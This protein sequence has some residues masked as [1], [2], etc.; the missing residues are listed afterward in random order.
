MI[1]GII[2]GT[3]STVFIAAAIAIIWQGR[4]PLKGQAAGCCGRRSASGRAAPA[5][6]ARATRRVSL[7][8]GGS[9]RHRAGTHRV[10]AGLELGAPDPGAHVLRLGNAARVRSRVRRGPSRRDAGGHRGVLPHEILAMVAGVPSMFSRTPDASARLR[11]AS[12]SVRSPSSSSGCCSTTS[13]RRSC[14]RRRSPP[15]R[16][17]SARRRDAGRGTR[18]VRRTREE[19][20]ITWLDAVLI[21]CAQACALIPGVSR[22]GA[23]IALGMF[24]GFR[25]DAAARF[26]FLLAIPAM[27]AAAGKE[28]LELRHMASRP[29]TPSCCSSASCVRRRRLRDDQVLP[30]LPR[31][32]SPRHF[33]VLSLRAGRATAVWIAQF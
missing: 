17:R 1:V 28:A 32:P 6:P 15:S 31:G 26:T 16:W 2:S 13:S 9:A 3:Y 12:S 29:P 27:L 21:G 11:S 24:L 22:S 23:T 8:R 7:R 25:R 5:K 14:A 4:R 19:R 10:P 18:W 33:R 20:V 30:A